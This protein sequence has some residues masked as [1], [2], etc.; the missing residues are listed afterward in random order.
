MY[1]ILPEALTPPANAAVGA[2]IDL[3]IAVVVPKL[4]QFA[5]VTRRLGPALRAVFSSLLRRPTHHAKHVLR[6][7]PVQ[8]VVFDRIMTVPAS[9]PPPTLEALH[10][11]IALVVLTSERNI[12]VIEVF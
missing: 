12:I 1:V 4:A 3:L 10:L 6:L 7:D 2:V 9:V 8:I 11:D 5:V